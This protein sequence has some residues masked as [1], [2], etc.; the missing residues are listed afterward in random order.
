MTNVK[1]SYAV[2]G[3]GGVGGYYGG[4]L[5]LAGK[6]VR[7]LLHSDYEYVAKH[8]LTVKSSDGDF[9]LPHAQAYRSPEAVGPVDVI[10]VC[11]KTTNEPLLKSLLPPMLKP[12]TTVVLIQN[13]VG[14]ETA[15]ERM[16]PGVR[17]VG[18]LAFIGSAKIGPGTIHHQ[19]FG[20]LNLAPYNVGD[21]EAKS[22]A[23]DMK[24]AGIAAKVMDYD[25]ARWKKALWNM[26]FNGLSVALDCQTDTLM[27]GSCLK[28][29][30]AL[31]DEVTGAAT[32]LGVKRV[33]AA[34]AKRLLEMTAKMPP[35]SPSMRLDF[36]ARRPMEIGYMYDAPI[37]MAQAAG[38]EMRNMKFLAD[39]L[40]AK[41]ERAREA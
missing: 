36:E 38:F 24:E 2:V 1:R 26:P 34:Y 11:L 41:E 9:A 7:F 6:D 15:V 16:V 8:G 28:L 17:L 14:V 39:I 32:A 25:E 35:Y 20:S 27:D 18:G 23:E 5:A 33:D 30:T 4:R 31:M 37:D 3:V 40:R 10:L 29:V 21:D 22:I 19:F 12:G 13:G